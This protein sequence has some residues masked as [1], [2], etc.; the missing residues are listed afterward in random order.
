MHPMR[1]LALITVVGAALAGCDDATTP[2]GD[3][4][5]ALSFA[6]APSAGLAGMASARAEATFASAASSL[7]LTTAELRME[8]IVLERSDG[9]GSADSDGDSD[10]DSD[11]DGPANQK[12]AFDDVTVALPL[13][14]GVVT[15]FTEPL[16]AGS[17]EELEMDVEA[18][19][20]VGTVDGEPF[21]VV[22]EVDLEL[23]MEFS[24]PLEIVE[25]DEPFSITVT[26]DPMA[27]FANDD[28]TFIDPRD[29]EDD[30][31]LL[32]RLRQRLAL[33][34]DAFEDSD[35]DG[36]DSDSR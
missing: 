17:Y 5:V 4:S 22:V 34:F 36:S 33:S 3:A 28:G 21:D 32:N 9:E 6:V 13:Q 16:P 11:S 20:L 2:E 25:G 35:R 12:L 26:V 7:T 8:E 31:A 14:G 23:E 1:T 29:L 18:I 27:W 15:P 19:R 24:P 10:V 30:D